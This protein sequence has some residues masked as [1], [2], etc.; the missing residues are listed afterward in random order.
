MI[1]VMFLQVSEELTEGT[2]SDV[3]MMSGSFNTFM[4]QIACD[5]GWSSTAP[6][7]TRSATTTG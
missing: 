2:A 1:F 7:T 4:S 3:Q 5:G 6:H